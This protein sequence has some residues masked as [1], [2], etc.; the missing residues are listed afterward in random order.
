MRISIAGVNVAI[1]CQNS[2]TL[3]DY[4]P[5][6]F[7][8]LDNENKSANVD[9]TITIGINNFPDMS[10]HKKIFDS[11][12]AWSMFMNNEDYF[13]IMNPH[14]S[15]KTP[16]WAAQFDHSVQNVTIFIGKKLVSKRNNMVMVPNLV[17]YPLD[18]ILLMYY[19]AQRN[20][21]LI[22]AAGLCF[23]DRGYIFP[24]KSGAGKSTISRQLAGL[25]G[26]RFL[27]DDRI[28]IR[29]SNETFKAFGT[30]WPGEAG[31][32]ANTSVP[33]SGIFFIS[34]ASYNKIEEIK[35]QEATERIFPVVSIPWYDKE[36]MVKILDFCEDLVSNVPVYE[37]HFKPDI[38]VADVF[39]EF[40]SKKQY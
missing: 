36:V 1:S 19:L 6:Y 4:E 10:M 40:V 2:V 17:C 37:L 24:G 3:Q 35:P 32:A 33:L 13:F 38:E 23:Q 8:F 15:H 5:I 7:S 29:K 31:I 9:I 28:I 22:H 27:S 25:N 18:Q 20:G 39:K 34:Q 14:D 26:Y 30:P 21:V 12:Q 16:L 11:G